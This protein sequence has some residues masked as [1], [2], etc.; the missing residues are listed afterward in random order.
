MTG[1]LTPGTFEQTFATSLCSQCIPCSSLDN[2]AHI[3][4][5]TR[6]V[7]G[8]NGTRC[9]NSSKGLCDIA[10]LFQVHIMVGI[11]FPIHTLAWFQLIICLCNN[12]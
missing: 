5:I 12:T 1:L 6:H 7:N 4:N 3:S 11:L 8:E 9:R 10:V 2:S